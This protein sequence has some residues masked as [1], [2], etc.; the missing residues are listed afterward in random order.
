MPRTR[1]ATTGLGAVGAIRTAG[2][3][4]M[5]FSWFLEIYR[6]LAKIQVKLYGGRV[7]H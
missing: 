5:G 7:F 2:G 1:R 6:E 3:F 4:E